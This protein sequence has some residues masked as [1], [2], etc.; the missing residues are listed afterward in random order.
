MLTEL[1]S[2][3]LRLSHLQRTPDVRSFLVVEAGNDFITHHTMHCKTEVNAMSCSTIGENVSKK[4]RKL[5]SL[6]TQKRKR[7][8]TLAEKRYLRAKQTRK[9]VK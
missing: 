9:S 5:S 7:S 2:K 4:M 3:T 8:P 1:P 6:I